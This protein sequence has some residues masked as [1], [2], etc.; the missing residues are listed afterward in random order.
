MT[1]NN[2]IKYGKRVSLIYLINPKLK[3]LL[4][5]LRENKDIPERNKWSIFGGVIENGET[6]ERALER[7]IRE[8]L[9]IP[10]SEVRY[11]KQ[12]TNSKN[13]KLY[14]FKGKIYEDN[15]KNIKISEGQK[16]AYFSPNDI[17]GAE[18]FETSV[19]AFYR[20]NRWR[21]LK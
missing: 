9:N 12:M 7:E 3:K 6:K 5:Y 13:Q 11:I 17:F 4:F 1:P 2:K 20:E 10:V 19:E 16:V 14:F 8:E 21:I 15:L 18:K